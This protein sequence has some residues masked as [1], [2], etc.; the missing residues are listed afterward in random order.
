MQ[1]I[2]KAVR[3]VRHSRVLKDAT[4]LWDIARPIYLQFLRIVAWRGLKRVINGQDLV[5]V[6]PEMRSIPEVYEPDVWRILRNEVRAGDII[7]DVGA[8][9]G[10]YTI[11]MGQRVGPSGRVYAFEP[12]DRTLRLL[13]RHIELNGL[14]GRTKILPYAVGDQNGMIAFI[15]DKSVES[16]VSLSGGNSTTSVRSVTLDSMFP[17][18]RIDVMKIDVEGFEMNVLAG[19]RELLNSPTR[20]PRT[21]FIEVH[22]SFWP[23]YGVTSEALLDLL[24]RASYEVFD[25]DGNIM[26]QIDRYGE[27]VAHR[28]VTS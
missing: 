10:L 13:R 16:H 24:R 26:Q 11:V 18:K 1:P 6:A 23:R 5:R 20:S 15:G 17:S 22:P 3:F 12:D 21:I 2:E 19:G 28:K 25:T 27:I 9:V 4:L 14:T 8:S 7:A